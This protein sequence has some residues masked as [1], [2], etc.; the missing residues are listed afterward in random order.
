MDVL[1]LHSM[2][3]RVV[4]VLYFTCFVLWLPFIFVVAVVVGD[5]IFLQFI[6]LSLALTVPSNKHSN[7]N[8]TLYPFT[9][10]KQNKQFNF[11]SCSI[12]VFIF[13]RKLQLHLLPLTRSSSVVFLS[14]SH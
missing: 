14:V 5:A 9:L 10:P 11:E 1:L 12:S 13:Q 6:F 7:M 3:V 8:L 2:C 4:Y